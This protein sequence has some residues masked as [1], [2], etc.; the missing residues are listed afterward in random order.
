MEHSLAMVIPT[1][2]EITQPHP[3]THYPVYWETY[4]RAVREAIIVQ[5]KTIHGRVYFRDSLDKENTV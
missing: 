5:S 4:Q 3:T 2:A 1:G